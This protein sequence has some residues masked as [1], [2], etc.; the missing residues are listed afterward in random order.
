M[1]T[2]T[3]VPLSEYLRTSYHPDCDWI[4]GE[5]RERNM[6]EGPHSILQKFFV[7]FL[8]MQEKEWGIRVLPEQRVQVS[9]KRY[10]IPDVCLALREG[11]LETI[12]RTPPILCIEILSWD[13]RMSEIQEKV[14]D[15][16]GMGVTA[17]WVVD[18][19]RRKAFYAVPGGSLQ[20]EGEALTVSGSDVRVPVA[21]MFAELDELEA[22]S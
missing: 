1:A 16:F 18:P 15:Y 12:V 22:R 5:V 8:G 6:G 10:R 4:D 19:R 9:S 20:A 2:S 17:V 11:P 14:D 13:D 7:L 21:E 3:L